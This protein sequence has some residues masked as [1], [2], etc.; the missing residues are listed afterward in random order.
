MPIAKRTNQVG[1]LFV[2][3]DIS[4]QC[5]GTNINFQIKPFQRNTLMVFWNGILQSANEIT[6]LNSSNFRTSFVPESSDSLRVY[7]FRL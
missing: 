4:S 5:T 2:N 3:L 6:I 7:F 1:N